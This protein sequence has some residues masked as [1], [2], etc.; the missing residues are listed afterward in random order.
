MLS[1]RLSL[2]LSHVSQDADPND[3]AYANV[4]HIMLDPSCSSSGMSQTPEEDPERLQGLADDQ[5]T[6]VLHAMKFPAVVA[7]CYSTC[8]V[9]ELENEQVVRRILKGQSGACYR[10]QTRA[11]YC[12]LVLD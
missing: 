1:L 7:V 2:S 4:T 8:S 9:H 5:T 11:P 10:L 12:L 3:P 6:L